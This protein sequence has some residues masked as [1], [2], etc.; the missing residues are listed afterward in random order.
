MKVSRN[1]LMSACHGKVSQAVKMGRLPPPSD[2]QCTDCGCTAKQYDHRDYRYPLKVDPVC[3]LCNCHR[4][5]AHPPLDCGEIDIDWIKPSKVCHRLCW[6]DYK[7]RLLHRFNVT[8][9]VAISDCGIRSNYVHSNEKSSS[10]RC[11][12][13]WPLSDYR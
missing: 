2:L 7:S 12:K 8:R 9:N 1:R 5:T 4:P 13:C 10:R 3:V 11:K 6:I